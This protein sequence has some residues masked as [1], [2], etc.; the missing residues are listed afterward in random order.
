VT[1][2]KQAATALTA[3]LT[4]ELITSG[5]QA[6]APAI[7]PDGRWVA[8]TAAPLATC[9]EPV[10][11][12]WLAPADGSRVPV[13]VTDGALADGSARASLPRWFADSEWLFYVDGEEIRRL[14][15]RKTGPGASPETLLRWNGEV[16]ALAPLAGG[17]LVAVAA[18]DEQ[19][20]DDKRR[21]A[22]GDDA[23]AW[24]ERAVRQH[25]LWHRLRVLDLVTGE[26]A[27][28]TGLADRHVTDLVQRPGGGPLAVISWECP[29]YEPGAFT[30]R[31]HHVT[32]DTTSPADSAVTDLTGLGVE[33]RSPA[34][35][36]GT[37]G[38]H[39]AWHEYVPS[40]NASCVLDLAVAADGTAAGGPADLTAG[41]P[42]CPDTL[43][44]VTSGPPMALFAEGLDTGLFR[45]DPAGAAGPVFRRVTGWPGR[46]TALSASD[47]ATAIA[48]LASTAY[49]PLDVKGGAPD[50]LVR[51]SDTRPGLRGVTWGS[52]ERLSWQAADGLELDGL[53]ILPP[54]R[55]RD[56]GP[57][58]L[59]TI[60]HGGPD[61]RWADELMAFWASWGQWLAAA[62]F[63]VFSPNP[64]G[65]VGHGQAFAT[66]VM[67]AVGQDEWT[68]TLAGLDELIAS[69]VADRARLGIAGW[70]HGGFMAAWAVTQTNRFKAAVM[71]AGIADWGIQAAA[72]EQGRYDAGLSGSLGWEGPGPH[73]HDQLS[74]VSYAAN[75]T[76]PVL[77][78][79]GADD[80]NV[81]VAQ[82][83]YFHRALT[84]YG[85]EHDLVL[86]PRENHLF[87][88]RAH[89]IDVLERVRAWFIRWLGDPADA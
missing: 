75:V 42:A 58:P 50:A 31:L 8:W 55:S 71:G 16:S 70:S 74:P 38:W 5:S 4:A 72:G 83:M 81:P 18:A 49:T 23:M 21:A 61:D 17:R 46:A 56:D 69:G 82:A 52:Q 86:Y 53:L 79:N 80:I 11:E 22:E 47:D 39:V 85:V 68:D 33:A 54:G 87:T 43:A 10:S 44:Q 41:L 19:T 32:L 29:E 48:V 27:V 36:C 64:R 9:G 65:G 1:Q 24:S 20:A 76:T 84:E 89:Q 3:E 26:F 7:S 57:F 30:S 77:I 25:W 73:R 88:E 51:L 12:L 45:L 60:I 67:G 63:A 2:V 78:L 37:D 34:W 66:V 62:G 40:G 15:V 59:V 28:V 35:W 14:R 6:G 13:Q